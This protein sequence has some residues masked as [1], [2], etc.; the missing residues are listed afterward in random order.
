MNRKPSN[1][2][3]PKPLKVGDRVTFKQGRKTVR[4][5]VIG[6]ATVRVRDDESFCG[7]E[8][9]WTVAPELLT[10]ETA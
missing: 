5:T 4:G 8:R 7:Y 1:T 6:T 9:T 2:K 10:K 3:A